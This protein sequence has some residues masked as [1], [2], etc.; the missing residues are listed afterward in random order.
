[1]LI[2]KLNAE[3][4]KVNY[5][6]H[7]GSLSFEVRKNPAIIS[8]L[9]KDYEIPTVQ[10][11]VMDFGFGTGDVLFLF[12]KLG[13]ICHGV[14]VSLEAINTLSDQRDYDLRMAKEDS[15]PYEDNYFDIVVASQSLEH[16]PDESLL[17]SEI[18]RVLKD[19]GT[20]ILGL[21]S[22]GHRASPLHFREYTKEDIGRIERALGAH[23]LGYRGYG[24]ELF[25]R[26]YRALGNIQGYLFK[27]RGNN[28]EER[29]KKIR[30]HGNLSLTMKLIKQIYHK[31]FVNILLIA[32]LFGGK[33]K[34]RER[35]LDIWF[36]F[37]LD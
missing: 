12:D 22:N 27:E 9:L 2:D 16:V 36:I 33:F 15:L 30:Q 32:F 17:F 18:K 25:S 24:G 20:V 3:Y 34:K 13:A 4:Y 11:K 23:C 7:D 37:C 35:N 1:M 5:K 26:L 28:Y 19:K 31:I 21:P 8:R 14:E 29:V 10:R 6:C